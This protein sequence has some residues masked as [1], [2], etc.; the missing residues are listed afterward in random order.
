MT[1]TDD[2]LRR[3]WIGRCPKCGWAGLSRD[4]AG[5]EAIADT[6]DF[7]NVCCP[8]CYEQEMTV[9]LIKEPT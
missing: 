1:Y 5:G 2:E 8:V 3:W 7:D 6:G 4:A 9:P